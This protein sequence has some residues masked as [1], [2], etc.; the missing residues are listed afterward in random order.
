METALQ[1]VLN[2]YFYW[3]PEHTSAA[4][5]LI[6]CKTVF[7]HGTYLLAGGLQRIPEA[8]ANGSKVLL[9]HSVQG[10]NKAP[11]GSYILEVE[12]NSKLTTLSAGAIVCATTASE[13][14]D[15][16]PDLSKRQKEFFGAIKYS[17]A[18]LLASTYD[19]KSVQSNKSIAFPRNQGIDLSAVTLSDE[20]GGG[21]KK[22]ST[23]KVYSSGTVAAKMVGL[24][25]Q[26][27]TS[28]LNSDLSSVKDDVLTSGTSP[29]TTHVQR[30][31]EALPYFDV[32]HFKRIANFHAG[33]VE[34]PKEH[35]TFA[36][37]YIGGPFMEGAFTSG[38]QAARRLHDRL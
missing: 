36:G 18:A 27:L 13:V 11:D 32:G 22:Y 29:I 28:R 23:V 25:D 10:V 1:P 33:H 6:L 3:N 9:S 8:A 17:S 20:P 7:S 37:D 21:A 35:I 15:I 34:D 26:E 16:F 14:L 2:G 38:L 30:W 19:R 5:M 31:H 12:C 24:S 4:M